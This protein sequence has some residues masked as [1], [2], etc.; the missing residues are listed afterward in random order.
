MNASKIIGILLIVISLGVGYI[1]VNKIA[2]STK[3]INFLGIKIDASN[4]SGQTQGFIYVGL[5]IVLFGG[6]LYAV[7][8]SGK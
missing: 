6:G 3:E 1:G 2:D 8:K 7:N 5:A 4:E